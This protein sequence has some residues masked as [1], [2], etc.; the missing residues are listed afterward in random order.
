MYTQQESKADISEPH[1][2]RVQQS[3]NLEG[4]LVSGES[5]GGTCVHDFSFEPS[6]QTSTALANQETIPQPTYYRDTF[7]R[8]VRAVEVA[9]WEGNGLRTASVSAPTPDQGPDLCIARLERELQLERDI[10]ARLRDENEQDL[11]IHRSPA[12]EWE[13][14][15]RTLR[16]RAE[17]AEQSLAS[18]Q[19]TWSQPR[20]E[21]ARLKQK[22]YSSHKLRADLETLKLDLR[23]KETELQR[24]TSLL[25]KLETEARLLRP[26]RLPLDATHQTI[27]KQDK[28]LD[29][30]RPLT[31][32]YQSVQILIGAQTLVLGKQ[33]QLRE[34]LL[35]ARKRNVELAT[36]LE[37]AQ[38]NMLNCV[39]GMFAQD[40]TK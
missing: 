16:V 28:D 1:A 33:R 9:L 14:E 12:A 7:R 15:R 2:Q 37:S 8:K 31:K 3:V 39:L 36:Q 29:L 11:R 38:C 27:S 6:A 18:E 22:D 10:P 24:N 34:G 32:E 5:I 4:R 25:N 30:L 19:R 35:K 17:S 21:C 40:L 20:D 13:E 23:A 26:R